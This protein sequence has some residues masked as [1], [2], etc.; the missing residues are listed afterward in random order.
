MEQEVLI[1]KATKHCHRMLGITIACC[2]ILI[3]I[4]NMRIFSNIRCSEML[5][6]WSSLCSFFMSAY[7]HCFCCWFLLPDL[8]T[9]KGSSS[10]WLN[11]SN[12]NYKLQL[13]VK[14][15]FS[16]LNAS[17]VL[18]SCS[19]LLCVWGTKERWWWDWANLSPFSELLFF[20]L[21]L[22]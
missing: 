5:I 7:F 6:L 12:W 13:Q 18:L 17:I 3:I 20:Y 22:W 15:P 10:T 4:T 1:H 9:R 11:S 8:Q 14:I 16:I 21:I 2:N 19:V